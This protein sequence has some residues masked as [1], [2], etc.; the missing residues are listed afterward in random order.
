MKITIDEEGNIS[1]TG[2]ETFV[3]ALPMTPAE[4]LRK[5]KDMSQARIVSLSFNCPHCLE[6]YVINIGSPYSHECRLES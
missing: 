2:A 4:T 5:G 6:V 1:P 3:V